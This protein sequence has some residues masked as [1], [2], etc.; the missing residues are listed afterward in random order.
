MRESIGDIAVEAIDKIMEHHHIDED[1]NI[2]YT[3]ESDATPEEVM[4]YIW[5]H[6]GN[7]AIHSGPK[8]HRYRI[9]RYCDAIRQAWNG[10]SRIQ[11]IDIGCGG[12]TFT[13]ALLEW[14][15]SEGVSLRKVRLH[16]YDYSRRMVKAAKIIHQFI[17]NQHSQDIP[18]LHAYSKASKLMKAIPTN[19]KRPAHYIITMGYVLA[20]NHGNDA[21]R[22]YTNIIKSI[23]SKARSNQC[24]L[25]VCDSNTRRPLD[26]AYTKFVDSLE[27]NGV[28]TTTTNT[29]RFFDTRI[30]RLQLRGV[31]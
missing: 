28:H 29:W 25:I 6:E 7:G 9:D 2:G 31:S 27:D 17:Q 12:G 24:S 5:R 13:W 16:S 8:G 20:N 11:H 3:V 14:C 26:P 22:D 21:I 10:T 19:P 23:C 15:I 4:Q 18:N 1:I 30:A